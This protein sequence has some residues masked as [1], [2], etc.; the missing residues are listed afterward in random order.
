[1][2]S[3]SVFIFDSS[4]P[5]AD[6]ALQIDDTQLHTVVSERHIDPPPGHDSLLLEEMTGFASFYRN[7]QLLRITWRKAAGEKCIVIA[8]TGVR[9]N[10]LLLNVLY[11][12][13]LCRNTVLYDGKNS[14]S[15]ARSWRLILGSASRVLGKSVLGNL[16]IQI[17]VA[18][19]RRTTRSSVAAKSPE[20]SLF[21]L[22]TNIHSFSVPLDKVMQEPDQ[23][24]IY[25]DY[26][27]GWYLPTLSN[28]RRRYAV[29]TTRHRLRDVVLHVEDVN[30]SAV[31]FLF[32]DER[33]LD[34]PYLLGRAR[35][36]ARYL[37]STRGTVKSIA[38]GIDLLYYTSGYYHWLLEGVPRILDLI[39][40]GVDFNEFPLI[41]PPMEPFHRQV[42]EVLGISPEHQVISVGRGDW[43][44]VGECIFPTA[45]F[46]FAAQELDDPSGQPD[47]ALLRKN[48]ER[49]LERIPRATADNTGFSKKIYI[50]RA[51]ATKR[52]FNAQTEAAVRSILESEGFRTVFLENLDWTEQVTLLS[53]AEFI[54]GLHGAGLANIL[55][56]QAKSL[57]EFQNP[58]EARPYFALMARELDMNYAYIIGALDGHSTNFDNITIEPGVLKDMLRRLDVA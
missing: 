19:F 49:L 23:R 7:L 32:K 26:A 8:A 31:R 56:S 22:Y 53:S 33:I 27:K 43:C 1:M 15:L 14:K 20:G 37:I 34:Y 5:S 54:V 47:A 41:L 55:F 35:P 39:D 45:N 40:D 13:L 12:L 48:R 52:R 25:G 57:L 51:M 2:H 10:Q 21:G 17:N 28:R 46:P 24:S 50:S 11:S 16:K 29:Q 18:L 38:R 4:Y 44:Y 36:T 9:R 6:V 42:L 3:P 58:L 30:D